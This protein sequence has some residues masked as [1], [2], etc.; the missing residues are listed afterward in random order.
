MQWGINIMMAFLTKV[1]LL[2]LGTICAV[3]MAKGTANC[4]NYELVNAILSQHGWKSVQC[5]SVVY[6]IPLHFFTHKTVEV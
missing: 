6:C 2:F 3:V 1:F 4:D 5:T